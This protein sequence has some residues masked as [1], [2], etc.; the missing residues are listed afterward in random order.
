MRRLGILME[1]DR[2]NPMEV[3]G[4][5]NPAAARGPDG[6][7]Y[8]FPRLVAKGNYSR[9]GI[10]RVLFD[11]QSDPCG[12]ER[13]GIALEP[14][15]PFEKNPET[16]GGCEDPRVTYVEPLQHYFMT[17][18]AYGPE[19]P[20]IA[21]AASRDL[22]R[23]QRLGL[24]RFGETAP[25]NFNNVLNKD[26]VLFPAMIADPNGVPSIGVIHRPLFPGSQPHEVMADLERRRRT[27]ETRET[28]ANRQPRLHHESLWISYSP[29][30]TKP[31]H[32]RN[33][34]A[35]HRLMSPR[36][37]WER[38]KV[39]AG[40]PPLLTRH[41]WLLIYHGV[42]GTLD[43]SRK[44]LRYSAGA[45]VLKP[46]QPDEIVYRSRHPTLAPDENEGEGVV[47]NV[48]FPTGIDQ[49]T[50]IGQPERVDVYYGMADD[51]IGVATLSIP[52]RLPRMAEQPEARRDAA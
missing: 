44:R 33:L 29:Q 38:I 27:H 46:N 20:R 49:R 47:P 52:A 12:V 30:P 4:V 3:E 22:M 39:G 7:L 34:E 42:C 13:L 32:L 1:P 14:E 37:S 21:L 45:L 48:V 25:V 2:S 31:E 6:A 8:L 11:A 50:D 43:H 28:A 9:I 24:L 17:Y 36:Y 51:R 41:G 16:G 40:A 23:W 10:A 5:L 35:H 19:G 18:T 15:E 26:A